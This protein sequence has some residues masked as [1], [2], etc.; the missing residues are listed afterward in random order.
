MLQHLLTNIRKYHRIIAITI[1]AIMFGL[2]LFSMM[3]DS[4]IVDEVAH[5]PAGYSYLKYGDFR[6]N[7]E[8]PP[9]IKDLAA[10]PL[11]FFNL[12]FPTSTAAWKTDV[13]GQWEA[14]W[15]FIYHIGN[16]AEL[17]LFWS[18]LPILLLSVV[19]GYIIYAFC[20]RRYGV[21]TG[22]LALILYAFS[23]SV[24]AHSRYVTTDLG[25][26]AATFFAF[27]AFF[28]FIEKPNWKT[29]SLSG[30]FFAIAQ[31]AKFS[32]ITLIPFFI[33][34]TAI[35]IWSKAKPKAVK[36][37]T[38]TYFGYLIF[39]FVVAFGLVWLFYIPHT[40]NMPA[41]AQDTLIKGS[42]EKGYYQNFGKFMVATNDGILLKSFYQYFLGVLMVFNRVSSGNITYFLGQVTNQSFAW[43]FPVSF[44]MK[45]Q[46]PLLIMIGASLVAV[47]WR[48]AKHWPRHV[49]KSFKVYA[50]DHFVE[51]SFALYIIF[52]SYI[53]IKGNLNLGIRHLFPM[54]P[55]VFILV[56][57]K[58]VDIRRRLHGPRR[59]TYTA[60]LILVTA[61]YAI[62]PIIIYPRYVPYINSA[63]GG[64][65]QGYRYLTDSNIDWGQDLK[66]LIE[67]V[68]AR[69]EI[70]KIAVDYFGG[71]LPKYY[72][73]ERRYYPNGELIADSNGYNCDASQ[74]LE[75]HA[76]QGVPPTTY[77]AV[78]ETYLMNDILMSTQRGDAGYNWLRGKEPVAKIGDSIYVYKIK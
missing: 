32:A 45:T 37:T 16:N 64:S 35:A 55:M 40:W 13:N 77:L 3:G 70:D 5:I 72:M 47:I 36:S 53:S 23:P 22:L 65:S 15:H 49:L 60:G 29:A 52:Y 46:I 1:L 59:R 34:L 78:S 6:L 73:C 14:G 74:Y 57:K 67:W 66:R 18:R 62:T 58:A 50:R 2:G 21:Q 4:A 42:L 56:A 12:K 11:M 44:L 26:A 68:E 8:H 17:I 41:I 69:P 33:G 31:L 25:I 24:I 38:K 30:V 10:M 76:Q 71:G 20:T 48:L 63:F 54:L 28:V 19:L 7:P 51:L 9:L 39:S 43:Y 75:W 61:L 27:L